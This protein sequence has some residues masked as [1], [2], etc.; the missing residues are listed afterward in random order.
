MLNNNYRRGSS[1]GCGGGGDSL[2][3]KLQ[4]IDFALYDTVLYLDAYPN[5][6]K[7]LCYYHK[8]LSERKKLSEMLG[9]S[10]MP[11]THRENTST[12]CWTWT[13]GP[14]PWETDAN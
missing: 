14:W 5:C 7:A 13:K 12:E 9:A 6:Q 4:M 3:K 10:D 1:C 2:K 11:M 8:L